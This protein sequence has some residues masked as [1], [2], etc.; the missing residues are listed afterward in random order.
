MLEQSRPGR[1]ENASRVFGQVPSRFALRVEDVVVE[2][3]APN[4]ALL[5]R[6]M[7]QA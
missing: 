4:L 3:L 5:L 6:Q 7:P 1:T 2:K